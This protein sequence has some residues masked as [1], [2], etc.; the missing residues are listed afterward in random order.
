MASLERV[1]QSD[2]DQVFEILSGISNNG[3]HLVK[4]FSTILIFTDKVD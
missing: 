1:M 2:L 3:T 4:Y